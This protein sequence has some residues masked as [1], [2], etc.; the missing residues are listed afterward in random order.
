M[1]SLLFGFG[2]RIGRLEFFVL[3]LT[4]SIFTTLLYVGIVSG[5]APHGSLTGDAASR[6]ERA[7]A[8]VENWS[9]DDAAGYPTLQ[10]AAPPISAPVAPPAPRPAAAAPRS[11]FGRRGL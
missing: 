10:A 11:G 4:L 7:R 3:S 5:L 2:G 6:K 9:P 1:V 8:V